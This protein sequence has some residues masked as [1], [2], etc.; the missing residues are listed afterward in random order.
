MNDWKHF[1]IMLMCYSYDYLTEDP[2]D[3]S[4]WTSWSSDSRW[5]ESTDYHGILNAKK[6]TK[7]LLMKRYQIVRQFFIDNYEMDLQAVGNQL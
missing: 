4:K 1:M 2:G 5:T 6:D 3:I 7:G